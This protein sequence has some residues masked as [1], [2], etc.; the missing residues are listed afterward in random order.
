MKATLP[1]AFKETFVHSS[2]P[3]ETF[4]R[5]AL[6]SA[7]V[8]IEEVSPEALP[9][10]ARW[11]AR[12]TANGEAVGGE[13]EIRFRDGGFYVPAGSRGLATVAARWLKQPTANRAG[14][15]PETD[16]IVKVLNR[17][18]TGRARSMLYGAMAEKRFE[19][20]AAPPHLANLDWSA[21]TLVERSDDEARRDLVEAA[22]SL[23]VVDRA[24]WRRVEEPKLWFRVNEKKTASAAMDFGGEYS[25]ES[26]HP[27]SRASIEEMFSVNAFGELVETVRE[28]GLD[29]L[30][31]V[32]STK[33]FEPSLFLFDRRR[34]LISRT[35]RDVAADF[36]GR[37]GEM[38]ARM[39]SDFLDLR[40]AARGLGSGT[41]TEDEA[42]RVSPILARFVA[43][44]RADGHGT[45]LR[46][47]I[48]DDHATIIAKAEGL[49][50][51][52]QVE[53]RAGLRLASRPEVRP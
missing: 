10:V 34:N 42:D 36:A 13:A 53:S 40:Q 28:A 30:E 19:G 16:A 44:A 15:R 1:F 51:T 21:L 20:F 18:T 11:H 23:L 24:L 38:S 5:A 14:G 12:Y 25:G 2:R 27:R 48:L 3:H 4:E 39:A 26:G 46:G 32:T 6:S 35:V 43:A 47:G 17:S 50:P 37:V 31:T 45:S 22:S 41:L 49:S 9:V 8:E 29:M 7:E 52:G 33:V